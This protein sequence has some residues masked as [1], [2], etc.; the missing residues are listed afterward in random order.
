LCRTLSAA[1]AAAKRDGRR[2][3]FLQDGLR[4][5]AD[6]LRLA[7]DGLAAQGA[8]RSSSPAAV[9]LLMLAQCRVAYTSAAR[10]S[11]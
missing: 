8:A 9:L 6:G 11:T 10:S 1:A 2:S 3:S 4:L 7:A 5:A